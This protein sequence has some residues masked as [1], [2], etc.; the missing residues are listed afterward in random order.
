MVFLLLTLTLRIL[1]VLFTVSKAA[2][3]AYDNPLG[4][5]E[6]GGIEVDFTAFVVDGEVQI[7]KV[8]I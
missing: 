3:Y 6:Q 8:S 1:V 2:G 4:E 7:A 5:E